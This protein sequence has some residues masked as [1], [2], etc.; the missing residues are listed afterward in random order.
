M[1]DYI[2]NDIIQHLSNAFSLEISKIE[3]VYN[4]D[5]GDE[6]EIAICKVLRRFLPNKYGICRGFVID[7]M[8]NSAGDDIIIYD[9]ELFPTLRVLDQEEEFVKKNQIPVEA[10]YAYIEAKYTLNSKSL[11]KAFKQVN[12]VK[13]L[14]YS[15]EL[16]AADKNFNG[17]HIFNN[18]YSKKHAWEPII[19]NPVYG[20]IISS[21]C[22][23]INNKNTANGK[24]TTD[25]L[26]NEIL[27]ILQ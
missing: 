11:I 6:F 3:A 17:K 16:L 1:D 21:N 20:M 12:D 8:G 26:F 14:C 22:T 7:K 23:N 13:R 4:F 9:Q 25:F 2:Y 18:D 27:K 10:V 15:R 5:Y 19:L 24:E